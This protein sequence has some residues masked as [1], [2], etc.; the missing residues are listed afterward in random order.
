MIKNS[1]QPLIFSRKKTNNDQYKTIIENDVRVFP[2]KVIFGK[3]IFGQGENEPF[4]NL[5]V[6]KIDGVMKVKGIP[7]TE[8][9]IFGDL[10]ENAKF[11]LENKVI[12]HFKIWETN[13]MLIGF[14]GCPDAAL[15]PV[16]LTIMT[17]ESLG[18]G[19]QVLFDQVIVREDVGPTIKRH[20]DCFDTVIQQELTRKQQE[21][22]KNRSGCRCVM[23]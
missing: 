3:V 11:Y 22:E 2:I 4:Q 9:T 19:T 13:F 14:E 16:K 20:L 23:L 1:V 17:D 12:S 6:I 15:V 7:D 10:E 21:F 5:A 8:Y 18:N